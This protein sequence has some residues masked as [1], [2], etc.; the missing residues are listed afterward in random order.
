[1]SNKSLVRAEKEGLERELVR[2]RVT[3]VDRERAIRIP[4]SGGGPGTTPQTHTTRGCR[5]RLTTSNGSH[6]SPKVENEYKGRDSLGNT[7]TPSRSD[8]K[9]QIKGEVL[10]FLLWN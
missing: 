7:E 5:F 6:R 4:V 2:T 8:E 9:Y 10:L 1:M 3:R